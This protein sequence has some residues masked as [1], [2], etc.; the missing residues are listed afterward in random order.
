M[1]GCELL[2]FKVDYSV[3]VTYLRYF[4]EMLARNQSR[5]PYICQ[6]SMSPTFLDQATLHTMLA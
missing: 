4:L 6:H 2:L 1:M 3:D 5:L